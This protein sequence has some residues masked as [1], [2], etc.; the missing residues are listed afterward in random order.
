MQ[1]DKILSAFKDDLSKAGILGAFQHEN[2]QDW[3][4]TFAKLEYVPA[5]STPA[6]NRYQKEYKSGST[7]TF[8]DTSIVIYHGTKPAG[9]WSTNITSAGTHAILGSNTGMLEPPLFIQGLAEKSRKSLT[10]Q[11]LEMAEKFCLSRGDKKLTSAISFRNSIG[12]EEWQQA[13]MARGSEVSVE[14]ELYT[15]LSLDISTIKSKFR[16]SY[17][18]LI[19]RGRALWD[20]N[21]LSNR[22]DNTWR[23]FQALHRDVAGRQ[24]RSSESWNIQH[25]AVASGDAFLVYLRDQDQRMIGGGFFHISKDEALYAVGAYDRAL[26]DKPVGHVVQFVAIEEMKKRNIRWY[27]IGQRHYLTDKPTPS[28]KELQIAEFKQGFASHIFPRYILTHNF[29]ETETPR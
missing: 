1:E 7:E 25:N 28:A 16:K 5:L 6:F 13:C 27:K 2:A 29:N 3:Q 22:D 18:S 14:H 10:R 19:T 21:D 12:I 15:D 9:I 24:T 20:V 26:F 4:D 11:C 17:K 23:E 8:V